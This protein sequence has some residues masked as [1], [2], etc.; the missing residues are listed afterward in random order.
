MSL[1]SHCFRHVKYI[2][3]GS[4]LLS[5]T[6]SSST[7]AID[8]ERSGRRVMG[9]MNMLVTLDGSELA[10]RAIDA[11]RIAAAPG[12]HLHLLS[13]LEDLTGADMPLFSALNASFAVQYM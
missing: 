5:K 3:T 1:L 4:K 8:G 2:R 13:V 10:E 11:A 12:A 7:T 9:Y 6:T